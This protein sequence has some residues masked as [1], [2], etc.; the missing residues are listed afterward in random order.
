MYRVIKIDGT[1]LGRTDVVNYIR[2]GKSGCFAPT[3][4]ENAIGVAYNGTPYNLLGFNT[5][6]GAET[7]LV[8]SADSGA[9][10]DGLNRSVEENSKHLAETDEIAIDLYET[11]LALEAMCAEHDEVMIDIYEKLEGVING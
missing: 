2:I 1:E 10:I 8:V 7:V 5:I 11:N 6:D 3:D 4:R 9:A